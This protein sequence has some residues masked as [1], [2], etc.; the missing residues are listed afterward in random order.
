MDPFSYFKLHHP[1]SLHLSFRSSFFFFHSHTL[2]SLSF[3]FPHSFP[4]HL[5]PP[6]FNICPISRC[7]CIFWRDGAVFLDI[8][9]ITQ[10]GGKRAPKGVLPWHKGAGGTVYTSASSSPS[11]SLL[12]DSLFYYFF[13]QFSA[14]GDGFEGKEWGKDMS[15]PKA[16][17]R[18]SIPFNW[19]SERRGRG[20][21]QQSRD[22]D[23]NTDALLPLHIFE[24]KCLL[25][26]N[27]QRLKTPALRLHSCLVII[28]SLPLIS[29][30]L[31]AL[32]LATNSIFMERPMDQGNTI[33]FLWALHC[34][35]LK[36]K[37]KELIQG[38]LK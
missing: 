37:K 15:T 6:F 29:S 11:L 19:E 28:S 12:T 14:G 13:I 1:H 38:E 10:M 31:A 30:A 26:H 25:V 36:K 34:A 21:W 24:W 35:S 8:V 5:E 3:V 7:V 32:S 16:L 4:H 33:P 22:K 9:Q 23:K 17:K 18:S 2:S 27:L 20:G